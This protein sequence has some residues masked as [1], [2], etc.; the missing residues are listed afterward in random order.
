MVVFLHG[1]A[2]KKALLPVNSMLQ[3][4][5]FILTCNLYATNNYNSAN[6]QVSTHKNISDNAVLCY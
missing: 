3:A 5:C 1:I 4:A 2:I 6:I